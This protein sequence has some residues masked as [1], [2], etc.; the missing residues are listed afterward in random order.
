MKRQTEMTMRITILAVGKIKEDWL[1]AGISEFSKRISRYSELL[2]DEVADASED[3]G[4]E[5]GTAEEGR[6]L[7]AR[8]KDQDFVIAL[9]VAGPAMDSA[10]FSS[11]L[12]RWM[13][14]A[15]AR[16]TFMIAGSNGYSDEALQRADERISLSS[17]TFPHTLVRLILLE[18]IFRAFKIARNEKYH[19]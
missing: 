14:K 5:K 15:G 16:V 7:L 4:I 8:I 12:T 1:K 6:R 10:T 17:L 11:R 13:D 18:Q 9:D 2:I 19:K 3:I